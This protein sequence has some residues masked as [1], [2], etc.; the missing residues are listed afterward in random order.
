MLI[1]FIINLNGVVSS[2]KSC[3]LCDVIMDII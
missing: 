2:L 1:L 3:I